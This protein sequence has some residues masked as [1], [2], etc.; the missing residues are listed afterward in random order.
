LFSIAYSLSSTSRPEKAYLN[1]V[2]MMVMS[3]KL[4]IHNR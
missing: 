4:L 3:A 1:D 2:V